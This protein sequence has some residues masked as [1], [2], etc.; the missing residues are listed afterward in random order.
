VHLRLLRGVADEVGPL[1]PAGEDVDRPA[2]RLAGEPDLDPVRVARP[3]ARGG[4]V[5]EVFLDAR[6]LP[7]AGTLRAMEDSEIIRA[8]VHEGVRTAFSPTLHIEHDCL[9]FDGWWQVG[10]RISPDVFSVRNEPPPRETDACD[11]L[12]LELSGRGLQHVDSNPQLLYTI[13]YT[14]I[15]LGLVAWDIYANDP[16]VAAA[17]L[18]ARAGADAFLGDYNTDE[19]FKEADYT[20]ELGGARKLAGLPPSI[21]LTVGVDEEKTRTIQGHLSDCRFVSHT[22]DTIQPEMCGAI[23]PT[24]VLVDASASA[25]KEFVMELRAVACGRFLPV[26]AVTTDKVVPLGADIT[27]DPGAPDTWI[28]PIR[29]LLP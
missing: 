20:A 23:I 28:E 9:F 15:A 22:F 29:R 19:P 10:F 24:V 21:V 5:T 11:Q 16:V 2:V 1:P 7:A 27:L 6:K 12:R 25:G 4:D 14:E 26:A 13:T 17:A 18:A 8:F 3:P